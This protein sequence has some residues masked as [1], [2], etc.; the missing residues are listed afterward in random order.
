MRFVSLF[1]SIKSF[2][3]LILFELSKY[4]NRSITLACKKKF[5]KI[6]FQFSVRL[7]PAEHEYES[8][9]FPSCPDIPKF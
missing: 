8:Q 2:I 9:F 5:P 4:N 1:F 6:N 7:F 3:L